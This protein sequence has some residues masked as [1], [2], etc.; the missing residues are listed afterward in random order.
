MGTR[1]SLRSAFAKPMG[2][3]HQFGI[4]LQIIAD[5]L[6]Q[7]GYRIS[8]KPRDTASSRVN[9][10]NDIQPNMLG[11]AIQIK[12]RGSKAKLHQDRPNIQSCIGHFI[13]Q[14]SGNV[15]LFR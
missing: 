3:L 14:N 1:Y 2:K 6:N 12:L 10:L 15:H 4:T 5:N 11:S 8:A 9:V 7:P 13:C